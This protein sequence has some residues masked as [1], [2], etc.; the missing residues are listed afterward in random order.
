MGKIKRGPAQSKRENSFGF[1][2]SRKGVVEVLVEEIK[3][4]NNKLSIVEE[5]A[6][7]CIIWTDES[8]S[9]RGFI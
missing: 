5:Y 7:V 9:S 3:L 4:F 1:L 6:H 8:L 2:N